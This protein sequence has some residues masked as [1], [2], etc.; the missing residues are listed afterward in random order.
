MVFAQVL[1]SLQ[2]VAS[3]D[4]PNV[5]CRAVDSDV[6][7]VL[8]VLLWTSLESM[9]RLDSLLFLPFLLLLAHLLLLT[10]LQLRVFLI[11]L[12]FLLLLGPAVVLY[13]LLL[14]PCYCWPRT[15][16]DSAVKKVH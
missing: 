2:L 11:F 3:P 9:L 16:S 14:G 12:G 13:P 4:V 1:V 8:I 7:D 10:S 6:A 5:S 15:L